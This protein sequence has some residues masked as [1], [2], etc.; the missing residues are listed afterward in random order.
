[1]FL[2]GNGDEKRYGVYEN[3]RSQEILLLDGEEGETEAYDSERRFEHAF[4]EYLGTKIK[5][6]SGDSSRNQK[7]VQIEFQ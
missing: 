1:M 2:E 5:L 3:R 4:L 7:S 6:E